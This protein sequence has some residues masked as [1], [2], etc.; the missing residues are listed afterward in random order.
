MPR[1]KPTAA[2]KKH[3]AKRKKPKVVKKKRG[4]PVGKKRLAPS[5]LSKHFPLGATV[6]G[7]DGNMWQVA[8]DK[9]GHF[10][11]PTYISAAD[12]RKGWRPGFG[13]MKLGPK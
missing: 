6:K 1:K 5:R 4:K 10:W 11:M 8:K 2:K 12:W 7:Y 3:V 13:P 9:E